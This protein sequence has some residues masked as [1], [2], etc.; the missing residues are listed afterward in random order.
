M[1]QHAFEVSP[2]DVSRSSLSL[3]A[4]NSE[5]SLSPF[6]VFIDSKGTEMKNFNIGFSERNLKKILTHVGG[7]CC[8]VVITLSRI[9]SIKTTVVRMII[10]V[11]YFK[12]LGT[13]IPSLGNL[14]E[15]INSFEGIV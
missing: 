12:S 11:M 8:D 5:F 4:I 15:M 7:I 10:I 1:V 2:R 6:S 9:V 13:P 3:E 14:K